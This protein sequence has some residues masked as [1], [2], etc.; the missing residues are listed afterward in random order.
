MTQNN[1][2]SVV[3]KVNIPPSS[4][5]IN[6]NQ[7]LAC[8]KFVLNICCSYEQITLTSKLFYK[9]QRGLHEGILL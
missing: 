3:T 1:D 5:N 6:K 7:I 9:R 2:I 8:N 4:Y